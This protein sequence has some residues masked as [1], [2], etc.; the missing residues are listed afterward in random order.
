MMRKSVLAMLAF[1]LVLGACR[2]DEPETPTPVPTPTTPDTA[3]QGAARA[4]A[5]SI[6]RENARRDE[7]ARRAAAMAEV[8]STLMEMVFFD[9]DR[10]EI[11]SD[12]Q[13]VMSRKA[14][15]LRANPNV[16]MRIEGHADERGSVEYNLALSLRRANAVREYFTG[17]GLDASRFEVAAFGEEQPLETGQ[18]ED[19]Y[20]RNRRAAFQI[21]RG[22]DNLNPVR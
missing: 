11:R 8:R 21:T 16:T 9:Y 5:D 2:K 10:A 6:A 1:G 19:A 15:A 17:A 18:S 13:D 14:A 20:A 22:G 7:D 4:R 12:M 3:G